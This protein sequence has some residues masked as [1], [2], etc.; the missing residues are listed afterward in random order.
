MADILQN[1]EVE[2]KREKLSDNFYRDE[3]ACK[4]GCG[5]AA[6]NLYLVECLQRVRDIVDVPII[7]NSGYRCPAHNKAI[8]GSQ[9]SRHMLGLAADIRAH[10]E[11]YPDEIAT[12]IEKYILEITDGFIGLGVYETF[13]HFDVLRAKDKRW[14]A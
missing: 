11:Y 12:V 13:V 5:R 9:Q 1:E 10:S 8:K 3:F 7:I 4:C 2:M 14:T 6:I